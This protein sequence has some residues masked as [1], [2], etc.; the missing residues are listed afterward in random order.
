MEEDRDKYGDKTPTESPSHSNSHP[1]HAKKQLPPILKQSADKLAK[2]QAPPSPSDPANTDPPL[3][4]LSIGIASLLFVF[5]LP[6]MFVYF[7]YEVIKA[8]KLNFQKFEFGFNS[9]V[10]VVAGGAAFFTFVWLFAMVTLAP[11]YGRRPF[12]TLVFP[13]LFAC[14][15]VLA[16]FQLNPHTVFIV[17]LEK[18][19]PILTI[20]ALLFCSALA[21]LIW[22]VFSRR[23]KHKWA[24]PLI[25]MGFQFLLID[26][27]QLL[28]KK[29]KLSGVGAVM[30]LIATG[31]FTLYLCF[32]LEYICHQREGKYNPDDYLVGMVHLQTDIFGRFWPDL[33]HQVKHGILS[34]GDTDVA[35][36]N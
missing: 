32:D 14:L 35:E 36:T 16:F 28:L 25:S 23:F 6:L 21:L 20:W 30:W 12:A 11:K 24:A 33:A 8:K 29:G 9:S 7:L 22:A 15:T 10:M 31:L 17:F 34:R 5:Y 19:R 13:T 1:E 4:W 2:G 27:V 26:E 3:N 18:N